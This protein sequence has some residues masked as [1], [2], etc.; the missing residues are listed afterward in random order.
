VL[1]GESHICSARG[2]DLL[3]PSMPGAVAWWSACPSTA[4]PHIACCLQ[5]G[6]LNGSGD[7]RQRLSQDASVNGAG[8]CNSVGFNGIH[9]TWVADTDTL[10]YVLMYMTST[11]PP[12]NPL[13]WPA[14]WR[15]SEVTLIPSWSQSAHTHHM[16]NFSIKDDCWEVYDLNLRKLHVLLF[17]T[18]NCL[19]I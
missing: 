12:L 6:Y 18:Y 10:I 14:L 5:G 17:F 8:W 9:M 2:G 4:R 3:C 7:G 16:H 19:A 13:P 11:H 15:C 1:N